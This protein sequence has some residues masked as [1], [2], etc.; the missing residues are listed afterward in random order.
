M[1]TGQGEKVDESKGVEVSAGGYVTI[2][3]GTAHWAKCV[4]DAVI[5]RFAHAAAFVC[6][7]AAAR[8]PTQQGQPTT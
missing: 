2:P 4:K 8:H 6:L 1:I 7:R 3:G 5:V